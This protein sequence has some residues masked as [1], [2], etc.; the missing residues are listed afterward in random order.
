MNYNDLYN[1]RYDKI[2]DTIAFKNK[3]ITTVYSG[4]ATPA[5]AEGLTI[6][7]YMSKPETTMKHYLHYINRLNSITPIDGIS[8]L[9][10]AMMNVALS[11]MWWSYV[12]MPGRELPENSIWQVDEKGL[13]KLEDYDFILNNGM[14]AMLQKLMPELCSMEDFQ[15]FMESVKKSPQDT[16]TCID[17]GYP[18]ISSVVLVPPFETLCG[19]R[20]MNNFFMDCYKMPDKVKAVQDVMME[21]IRKQIDQIPKEKHVLSAFIGVSRG[22]SNMVNQKIWD[23]LVW[24]DMK[25]MALL[26]AERGITPRFHLDSDWGRDI[27]H[28]KELPAKTL[29]LN[30]DGG[31]DLC[32]TRKLLGDHAAFLG[33]VPAPLLAVASKEEVADYVKHLIDDVGI[34]GLF[35]CPGCD[36]PATAKFENMVAMYETAAKYR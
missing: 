26:I 23:K 4:N 3:N 6:A 32:R 1:Q 8:S 5:A 33:D 35:L 28:L 10:P 18:I 14:D 17:E 7:E 24:P 12:K 16:Q 20:S 25:E 34:Q 2:K 9:H 19:G 36:A 27:E 21:S 15:V 22:A 30:T 13:L 11:L 31:T 29:I